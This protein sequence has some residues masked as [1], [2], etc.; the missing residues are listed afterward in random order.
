MTA[1]NMFCQPRGRAG[2]IIADTAVID[3]HGHYGASCSKVLI[4]VGRLPFA[5][6]I[7]GN[8][9]PKT[10]LPIFGAANCKTLK[11]LIK[12][13]P[14][15]LAEATGAAERALGGIGAP[16]VSLKIVAWDFAKNR[17]I[18]MQ[19]SNNNIISDLN[20]FELFQTDFSVTLHNNAPDLLSLIGDVDLT[21]PDQFDPEVDGLRMIEAQRVSGTTMTLPG[22]VVTNF[23]V[24]GE[25]QLYTVTKHGVS[26]HCLREWPD[27]I[28][29]PL[30][31]NRA[32]SP[33]LLC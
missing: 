24:G 2:Y 33:P 16:E 20:T 31:P 10:L 4:S 17:P 11:Q 5:I 29:K 15:L 7:T 9:H 25:A 27:E 18:G 12:R 6:G 3:Q 21:D 8:V 30:D 14:G 13:L 32:I 28:G 26:C 22:G 23:T 1:L 19:I